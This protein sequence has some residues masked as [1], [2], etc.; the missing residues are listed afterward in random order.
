MASPNCPSYNGCQLVNGT[1]KIDQEDQKRYINLFCLNPD[2][3]WQACKRFI[4]KTELSFCPDFVFPD[5]KLS[6]EEIIE[7]YDES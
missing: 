7:K 3:H 6:A 2:G 1:L 4:T 5:T